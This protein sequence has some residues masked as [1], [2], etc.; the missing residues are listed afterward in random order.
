MNVKTLNAGRGSR[1]YEASA[2]RAFEEYTKVRNIPGVTVEKK[3]AAKAA[4]EARILE[5]RVKNNLS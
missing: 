4:Y 3:A 2:E 1:V 5:L